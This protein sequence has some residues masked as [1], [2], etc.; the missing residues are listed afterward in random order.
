MVQIEK[1]GVSEGCGLIIIGT[2]TYCICISYGALAL[3]ISI[4]IYDRYGARTAAT[5]ALPRSG[6]K[7]F[8]M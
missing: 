7:M 4:N 5:T 2:C 1:R 8:P 3:H 6:A